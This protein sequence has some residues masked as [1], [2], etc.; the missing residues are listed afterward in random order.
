MSEARYEVMFAE[1][2]VSLDVSLRMLVTVPESRLAPSRR[3]ANMTVA[4]YELL[5]EVLELMSST[6][7]DKEPRAAER[8]VR[9]P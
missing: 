7:T 4:E 5:R 3:H 1:F 2:P 6:A 8:E 9:K